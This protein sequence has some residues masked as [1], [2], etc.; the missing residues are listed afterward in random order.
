MY[1]DMIDFSNLYRWKLY[2]QN[3][4]E[5]T[6]TNFSVFGL[7]RPGLELTIYRTRIEHATHYTTDGYLEL[8]ERCL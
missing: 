7:T 2:I 8:F 1:N 4:G 5:A 3:V 6:N